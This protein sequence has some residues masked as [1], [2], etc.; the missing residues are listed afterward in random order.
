MQVVLGSV[1][2]GHMVSGSN[3]RVGDAEREAAATQLRD[4][5]ADGRLT[6]DELNERLDKTFAAK[7]QSDLT[8]LMRDLPMTAR[9]VVPA[10]K[11]SGGSGRP[12]AGY[13]VLAPAMAL[14]WMVAAIAGG[15]FL[16]G[17]GDR[18]IA[19]V[20]F[21]AAL[22]FFRRMIFGRRRGRSRRCGR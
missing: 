6:L 21:L 20:L 12:R 8:A 14:F 18:P 16:F 13:N 7:T 10:P 1:Y 2:G 5:Y 3:M 11:P 9:P 4:H 17:H 15:L 22:A 19:I